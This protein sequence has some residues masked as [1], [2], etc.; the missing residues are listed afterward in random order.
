MSD[1]AETIHAHGIRRK[2]YAT[3]ASNSH[4]E[5]N[6]FQVHHFPLFQVGLHP[7][8]AVEECQDGRTIQAGALQEAAIYKPDPDTALS[9]FARR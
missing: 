3:T 5:Q 7:S 9:F 6:P 1:V 8:A 4:S 2:G